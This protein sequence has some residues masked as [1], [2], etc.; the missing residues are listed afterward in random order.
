MTTN[1]RHQTPG[2]D[3]SQADI[4]HHRRPLDSLRGKR[5]AQHGRTV[6][7]SVARECVRLRTDLVAA[8]GN[9]TPGRDRPSGVWPLR[10]ERRVDV[11]AGDGRIHRSRGRRVW[12][13]EAASRRA[14]HWHIRLAVRR[15]RAP[16]SL[17]QP[18]RRYRRRGRSDSTR[19]AVA[20]MGVCARPR[21]VSTARWTHDRRARD[22]DARALC[23]QRRRSRG[24]PGFVRGRSIR[25]IDALRAVVPDG[26]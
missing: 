23:A 24:L 13:R 22:S 11:A 7:Q 3:R 25:G 8:G 5:A 16:R 17:P 26:A 15:G 18:R 9:D 14:R 21:T 12:P 10:A 6:A 20:R 19:R 4:S 2:R 1:Q